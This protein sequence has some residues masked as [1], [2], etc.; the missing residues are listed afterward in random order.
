LPLPQTTPPPPTQRSTPFPAELARA[1]GEVGAAEFS[2]LRARLNGPR[3]DARSLFHTRPE[4]RGYEYVSIACAAR[5]ALAPGA[6]PQDLWAFLARDFDARLFASLTAQRKKWTGVVRC[7]VEIGPDDL[8][9]IKH[10]VW[11]HVLVGGLDLAAVARG[12][13][14]NHRSTAGPGYLRTPP[15]RSNRTRSP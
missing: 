10:V 12:V 13:K 6:S 14:I 11:A 9:P 2:A 5:R 4:L 15:S 1:V 8:L 7:R 3:N